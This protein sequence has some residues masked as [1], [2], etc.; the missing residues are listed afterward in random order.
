MLIDWLRRIHLNAD[1]ALATRRWKVAQSFGS[2]LARKDIIQLVRAFVFAGPPADAIAGL[3]ENFLKFDN[4]FPPRNNSEEVRLMAGVTMIAEFTRRS[5][6]ADALAL[7]LKAAAYPPDRFHPAEQGI[8]DEAAAYLGKEANLLRPG[9]FGGRGNWETVVDDIEALVSIE[10]TDDAGSQ[11][12]RTKLVKSLD[13]AGG[14]PLRRLAEETQLL[15]W[16]LGGYSSQLDCPIDEIDP[17]AYALVAASEITERVQLLPP[18]A[19][20]EAI[21][22]KALESRKPGR[23]RKTTVKRIISAT[24]AAWRARTVSRHPV[25]DCLDLVPVATALAKMEE[26]GDADLVPKLVAKACPGFSADAEMKLEDVAVQYNRELMFVK[27]L[28][29]FG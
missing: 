24:D 25:A 14:E 19:A 2:K 12:A 22:L 15:W 29:L 28:E 8:V 5:S 23:S 13:A 11:K 6:R 27:A 9:Q 3:T 17:I 1:T 26:A 16:L 10:P 7:G 20:I 4:E 21:L 18:P